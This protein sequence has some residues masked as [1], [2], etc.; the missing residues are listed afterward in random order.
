MKKAITIF[1][2]LVTTS[3]A[4]AQVTIDEIQK[5]QQLW[6]KGKKALSMDL[7][8]IEGPQQEAFGKVFDSYLVDRQKLGMQRVALIDDLGKNVGALDDAKAKTL[9]NGFFS[10]NIKL[11][12]LQRKYFKKFSKD[13]SPARAAQWAQLESY[14]DNVVR[15]EMQDLVPFIEPGKLKKK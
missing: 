6:G 15:S 5:V 14:L 8:K 1:A 4:M 11:Q 2:I 3:T 13:L 7:L 10:N 12:K 9:V